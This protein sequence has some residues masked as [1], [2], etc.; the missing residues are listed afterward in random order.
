MS[1]DMHQIG[2]FKVITVRCKTALDL[3][4]AF[5]QTPHVE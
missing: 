2:L 4:K 1:F 5:L 3:Q